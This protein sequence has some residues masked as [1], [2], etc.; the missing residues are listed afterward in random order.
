MAGSLKDEVVTA[1]GDVLGMGRS[2]DF[3]L[4]AGGQG[5][6]HGCRLLEEVVSGRG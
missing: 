3:V 2:E 4:V 6:G 5:L 1:G